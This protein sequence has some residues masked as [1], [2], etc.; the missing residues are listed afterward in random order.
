M[1][2]TVCG[3]DVTAQKKGLTYRETSPQEKEGVVLCKLDP[4]A[5]CTVTSKDCEQ[6]NP[7]ILGFPTP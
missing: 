4:S 2:D 3:A 7:I 1:F 5:I 6:E